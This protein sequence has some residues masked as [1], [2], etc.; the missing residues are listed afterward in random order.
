MADI[1]ISQL[2]ESNTLTGTEVVPVVQGGATVKTTAQDIAD[3]ANYNPPYQSYVG[4]VFFGS[5]G[6][7]QTILQNDFTGV[8]LTWSNPSTNQLRGTFS[9]APTVI[10]NKYVV[11]VNSY[12][13]QYLVTPS[14]GGST[15][16]RWV[17]LVFTKHDGTTNTLPYGSFF[18]EIRVYP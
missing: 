9:T 17:D 13:E 16:T 5:L 6:F 2:E 18:I 14:V 10:N 12:M 1:K 7:D 15:P 4:T 11:F 8:T 3:L